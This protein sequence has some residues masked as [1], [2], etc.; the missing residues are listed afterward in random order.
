[1][2]K[3]YA[4]IVFGSLTFNFNRYLVQ[5]AG[6]LGSTRMDDQR[7]FAGLSFT[8]RFGSSFQIKNILP[9]LDFFL[10]TEVQISLPHTLKSS[11]P[12]TFKELW[13]DW[14]DRIKVPFGGNLT[15]ILGIQSIY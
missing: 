5:Q 4:F 12:I 7:P 6:T 3:D 1:R 11:S 8:P 15:F 9:K 14:E 13:H 2:Q 10:S